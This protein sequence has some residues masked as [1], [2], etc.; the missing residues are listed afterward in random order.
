MSPASEVVFGEPEGDDE[1]YEVA[2]NTT[3]LLNNSVLV[4]RVM[5]AWLE[6]NNGVENRI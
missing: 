1:E 5:A 2:F 6:V 4:V 3:A